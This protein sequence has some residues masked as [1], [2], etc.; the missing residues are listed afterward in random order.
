MRSWASLLIKEQNTRYEISVSGFQELNV[1]IYKWGY[2][3]VFSLKAPPI[4]V[5]DDGPRVGIGKLHPV[6]QIYVSGDKNLVQPHSLT[7]SFTYGCFQ[8]AT[9][10]LNSPNRDS[11]THPHKK[12]KILSGPLQNKFS[13]P[14][15]RGESCFSAS[16]IHALLPSPHPPLMLFSSSCYK[17]L[18]VSLWVYSAWDQI[19][20]L[21]LTN[22]VSL[23]TFHKLSKLHF[24]SLGNEIGQNY[25][26]VF[27]W[28][29][30]GM[31]HGNC[32]ESA[33]W[34]FISYCYNACYFLHSSLWANVHLRISSFG[35][36]ALNSW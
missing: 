20:A 18:E 12:K 2:W 33:Q 36:L 32:L 23:G 11:I 10:E 14:W 13:S 5:S 26:M 17:N 29:F 27:P 35:S 1:Q 21:A 8:A 7:L 6:S 16:N 4:S 28:D 34:M 30:N 3:H 25:L 31:L 19:L 15:P 22:R 24:S 9:A